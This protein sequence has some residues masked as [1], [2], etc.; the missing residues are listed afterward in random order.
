MNREII[1][2]MTIMVDKRTYAKTY[3]GSGM[4][5]GIERRGDALKR[6]IRRR[7]HRIR[8]RMNS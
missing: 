2:K 7:E 4:Q 3:K 1:R 6:S 8:E 5:I